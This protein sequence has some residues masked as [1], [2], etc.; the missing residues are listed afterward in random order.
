ME[1]TERVSANEAFIR[2]QSRVTL[3]NTRP[4]TSSGHSVFYAFF[5]NLKPAIVSVT[6]VEES[7]NS[8]ILRTWRLLDVQY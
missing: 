2:C 4:E 3:Q 6:R 5:G 7:L 1:I 8:E